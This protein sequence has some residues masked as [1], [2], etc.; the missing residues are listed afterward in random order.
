MK[1]SFRRGINR[2]LKYTYGGKMVSKRILE[3]GEGWKVLFKLDPQHYISLQFFC[4]RC[5]HRISR[6][7]RKARVTWGHYYIS[8]LEAKPRLHCDCYC[9]CNTPTGPDLKEQM[10]AYRRLAYWKKEFAKHREQFFTGEITKARAK[11]R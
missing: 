11:A 8:P 7:L 1:L 6:Q 5:H 9:G 4:L 2:N 3:E 10:K